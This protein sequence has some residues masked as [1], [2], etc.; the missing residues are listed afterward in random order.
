MI[1]A[2]T[3]I[4]A[5]VTKQ[6]LTSIDLAGFSDAQMRSMLDAKSKKKV[7]KSKL[8]NIQRGLTGKL[9]QAEDDLIAA[10]A[11]TQMKKDFPFV[12][13]TISR[14]MNNKRVIELHLD[15]LSESIKEA[16]IG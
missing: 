15:G 13:A 9:Q 3:Q 4:Q 6:N 2:L 8:H 7:S 10:F 12:E 1:D 11:K 14:G 5:E 16:T